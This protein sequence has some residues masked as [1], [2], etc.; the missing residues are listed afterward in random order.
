[1]MDRSSTAR[2]GLDAR[3]DLFST[4]LMAQQIG[5]ANATDLR[6]SSAPYLA[7]ASRDRLETIIGFWKEALAVLQQLFSGPEMTARSLTSQLN[8]ASGLGSQ[9]AGPGP[10]P[11]AVSSE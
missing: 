7:C 4:H 2:F 3:M 10:T 8:K 5:K 1:M 9:P 6:A 11:P